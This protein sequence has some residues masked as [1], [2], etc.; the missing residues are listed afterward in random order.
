MSAQDSDAILA[1]ARASLNNQRAGGRRVAMGKPIGKRSAAMRRAQTKRKALIA[2][3]VVLALFVAVKLV[4]V[5]LHGIGLL[6]IA[7]VVLLGII[8]LMAL[9]RSTP[10]KVPS[11]EQLR[12]APAKTL[13]VDTQVWL[14]AQRPALPAPALDL[15]GQ[16]GGQLDQLATQLDRLDDSTPAVAQVRQLVGQ[17]LP[18][19]VGAYTAIPPS[20]RSAKQG[21]ASPDEQLAASLGKIST[22]ID[23][24][25][26]QLAEGSIDQLA[27]QTRFLDYKYGGDEVSQG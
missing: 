19:L 21:E 1:A 8:A 16:I 3:A 2:V 7:G 10:V 18:D 27:I 17:H 6:A 13:V 15:V 5:I 9:T 25:T 26:R 24:V 20:L 12:S 4:G 14:E 23:S 22:E 11:L